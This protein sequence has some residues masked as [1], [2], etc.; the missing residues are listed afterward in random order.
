MRVNPEW[1]WAVKLQLVFYLLANCWI[2]STITIYGLKYPFSFSDERNTCYIFHY[3]VSLL[4]SSFT[5]SYTYTDS[6]YCFLF[7]I[8]R[9]GIQGIYILRFYF[10]SCP[11]FC[12]VLSV[13]SWCSVFPLECIFNLVCWSSKLYMVDSLDICGYVSNNYIEVG[14][15]MFI[16]LSLFIVHIDAL[17]HIYEA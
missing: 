5:L 8:T 12:E 4:H 7:V 9:F 11:R 14:R 16:L 17:A 1:N 15:C 3:L 13:S 6:F 10:R 2:G